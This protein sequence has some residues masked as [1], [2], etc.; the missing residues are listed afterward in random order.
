[1]EIIRNIE[2]VTDIMPALFGALDEN[3]KVMQKI[4][5]VKITTF[6]GR[7]H[8]RGESKDVEDCETLFNALIKIL[9]SGEELNADKVRHAID[10][11]LIN[12]TDEAVE[13][14]KDAIAVTSKGKS[15]KC[16]TLGQKQYVNSIKNNTIVLGVGPA[17]TGK[18]YLA[19]AMAV[20]A[21]KKG[22][23]DK[24]ILTRP[25]IEAGEKLGFLP[26]D[27]NMKVDPYL[28]PL[29]DALQ[30]MFGLD[31]YLKL[32]ERGIVE[33]APLAYMR[34]RTLSNA[35]IILDE[36]Q[37]TTI[38]QMKMFLTRLGENSKMIINGDITQVDLPYGKKSGLK[39]AIEVLKDVDGIS[40]NV[41]T[42]KD[43]VRNQLVQ[44]I[45]LAYDKGERDRQLDNLENGIDKN[46][47]NKTQQ[48][49]S[50]KKFT[51][52]KNSMVDSD[53]NHE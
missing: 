40:I 6:D 5:K 7:I 2:V 52:D 44:R 20:T 53:V 4:L 26:G 36:A 47:L 43:I 10:M 38:E 9:S 11:V 50:F 46:A 42:D 32:I 49:I 8:I 15:I 34:G 13:M 17:G 39:D 51:E 29:F 18:T 35:Y 19:V 28:R 27:L 12:K 22:Q 33:I 16:K 14:S 21:Y 37:N 23:V 41:L 45:V 25:A 1:M 48:L 30:E 3:I 24:I 31:N